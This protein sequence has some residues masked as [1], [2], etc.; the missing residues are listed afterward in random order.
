M[1]GIDV[2]ISQVMHRWARDEHSF[3]YMDFK[4]GMKENWK[5]GLLFGALDGL[6]PLVFYLC[7]RFYAGMAAQSSLFL[8]PLAVACLAACVWFLAAPLVPLLIVSYRQ[9]L[10]GILRNAVLM[11]LAQ[12]PRAVGFRL[13][14]LTVPAACLASLLFF[15]GALRWLAMIA[16]ALYAIILLA[17]NKL[18]WASFANFLGEK[19]LNARIPG[20]PTNIGLRPKGE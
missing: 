19:Y 15:P 12:L 11:A 17:F 2:G 8:L 9:S 10:W 20:A 16:C 14:T 18:I 6:V 1:D 13:L 5:Q 7:V 4:I 3:P